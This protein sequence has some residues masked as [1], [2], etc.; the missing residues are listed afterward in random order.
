MGQLYW[1]FSKF[2]T[3]RRRRGATPK[4]GRGKLEFPEIAQNHD[5]GCSMV[6]SES[7]VHKDPLFLKSDKK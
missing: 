4:Y 7:P 5:C 3:P 6:S 1:G 2:Q